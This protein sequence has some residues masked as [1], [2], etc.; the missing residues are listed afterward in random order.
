MAVRHGYGKIAGTDALVFAYDTGDTRNSYRGEPTV[1]LVTNGNFSN[2]ITGWSY[3]GSAASYSEVTTF[4]G[5]TVFKSNGLTTYS[6]RGYIYQTISGLTSGATY[7]ISFDY[8]IISGQLTYDPDS[9]SNNNASL[10]SP[11]GV[12][13]THTDT[14]TAASTAVTLNF[15]GINGNPGYFYITN[16]QCELKSHKTPFVNGTRSATQ[17]LLDLTGNYSVDL[18]NTSFNS[19]ADIEFDGSN[20]NFTVNVDSVIRNYT[21]VTF[22]SVHKD[23][24]GTNGATPYS[25][26]TYPNAGN[27]GDG[28]WHHWVLGGQWYWRLE[29]NVNGETGGIFSG[30]TP[31]QT[32]EWYHVVAVVKTNTILYYLNGTLVHTVNTS[33]AWANLRTDETAYL[34]LGSGYGNAY[35]FGGNLTVFKMYNRELTADEVR[36]NYSH[37]KS[38][39]NI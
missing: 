11:T 24:T 30:S 2:G 23:T 4:E 27:G 9:A 25:L 39:F 35:Y 29:D 1:N 34:Y 33:F 21:A 10:T 7:T 16:I 37:Y 20:D 8:Y 17:G 22:E 15:W 19:N 5:R 36:N 13:K 31:F 28:F 6:D 12:W 26:L 18:S 38:R 32:G 14:F 3:N